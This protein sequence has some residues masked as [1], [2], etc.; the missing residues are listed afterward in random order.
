MTLFDHLI[1][2]AFAVL[3]PAF[4]FFYSIPRFKRKIADNIPGT[5]IREYQNSIAWIWILSLLA[6]IIWI[7]NERDLIN[8]GLN[9]S[10]VWSAWMGIALAAIGLTYMFFV[11]RTTKSNNEQ[12][13]SIYSKLK[14]SNVSLYLPHTKNDF[15]WFV[16]VSI[17]AGIC[18]ELLF[19]GFLIWYIN[20][21]SSIVFAV[22]LSSVLFA[23]AHA[24]QGW[25]GVLQSGA[26]GLI[27]AIIYVFTDTLWIP[28]ALH[29]VVDMYSGML[30]WLAFEKDE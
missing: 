6:L 16:F 28:I 1:V 19:R 26:A 29:I 18:E 10:M 14:D 24:Y 20:E 22:I 13:S 27:L 25:K 5:R 15:I 12:R 9:F 2:L 3:Y 8:L 7:N 4:D 11:L 30:G 23:F 21:F 17:S